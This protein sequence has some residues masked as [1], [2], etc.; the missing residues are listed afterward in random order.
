MSEETKTDKPAKK[1]DKKFL[2]IA[3]GLFAVL[4]IAYAVSLGPIQT[5]SPAATDAESAAQGD[6]EIAQDE[7]SAQPGELPVDLETAVKE[8]VLGDPSAPI[9]IT[10]HASFTCG[11]CGHFHKGAFADLKRDY[12]DTGKAYLVFSDFPLNAPALSASTLARCVPEERYFDFVSDLFSDQE[13]WAFESNYQDLLKEKAAAYGVDGQTADACMQSEALRNALVERMQ[14]VGKQW[15]INSTPSFVV[16]NQVVISGALPYA[17]F[18]RKIEE[19]AQSLQEGGQDDIAGENG[20]ASQEDAGSAPAED[21]STLERLP[22]E[23]GVQDGEPA[24]GGETDGT[25][26]E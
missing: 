23:D 2:L 8:R 7:A 6:A 20:D 5:A 17:E 3:V 1:S 11:H 9:K 14:A 10:E 13:N 24:T 12:I 22:P 19:A 16:N 26:G 18:S 15:E 4:G 25:A 21:N